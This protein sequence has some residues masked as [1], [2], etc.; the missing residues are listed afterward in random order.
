MAIL[1]GD[2]KELL[3]SVDKELSFLV[4]SESSHNIIK[5]YKD[6]ILCLMF[7]IDIMW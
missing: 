1:N 6:D 2:N 3:F 4:Y 5:L 7:N